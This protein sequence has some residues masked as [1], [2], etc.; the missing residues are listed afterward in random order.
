MIYRRPGFLASFN[1]A[2]PRQY[3]GRLDRERQI[4]DG[5]RG[6]GDEPNHATT[7]KPGPLQC[8]N[9]TLSEKDP[10]LP[11]ISGTS[12]HAYFTVTNIDVI[13]TRIRSRNFIEQN[14]VNTHTDSYM[15]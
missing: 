12:I 9:S 7:R 14:L 6:V 10:L 4:D 5:R 15:K 3:I 13:V 11:Q 1:L 2:P 8:N